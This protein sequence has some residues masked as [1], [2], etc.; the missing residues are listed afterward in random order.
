VKLLQAY[1]ELEQRV[2]KINCAEFLLSPH[3]SGIDMHI[4]DE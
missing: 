3:L 1:V 2:G 4:V